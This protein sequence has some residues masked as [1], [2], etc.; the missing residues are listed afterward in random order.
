MNQPD[1][2]H[3]SVLLDESIHALNIQ[4]DGIYIDATFGRGGH[5]QAILELLS[6]EGQLLA[7]DRDPMAIKSAQRFANDKRFTIVHRPF[8]DM[9]EVV[10]ELGL[11]GRVSGVLMDLGV[12]SPQLDDASRGFSFM[13]EG[14]LDMRMDTTH[15][16]SAAQWLEK[17]DIQDITQVLKEFGEEKFGKR[18]AHAIVEYRADKPLKTTKQLA[19]LIDQA[20]PVKD[21]YK[22]PATRSF[23]GIRIYINAEL[24]QLREGLKGAVAALGHGGRLAVISF[25]SLEDRMV[26]RFMREQ[27]KGKDLPMG[28]PVTQAEIDA[29]KV[30]KLMSKAIK[31]SERELDRNIRARSSVLRV[32]EKL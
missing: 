15:G 6:D 23:Q 32:A 29:D 9:A 17:A 12:S 1:Y 22:H 31:P 18:I 30:L 4:P 10:A 19:D 14:P 7:F 13:R 27:S 26:K 28:L 5:S 2:E 16:I 3:R 25:H 20:V 24:E 8:S 21:K 11:T